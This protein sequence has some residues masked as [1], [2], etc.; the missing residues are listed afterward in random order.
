MTLLPTTDTQTVLDDMLTWMEEFTALTHRIEAYFA[1][2]EVRHRVAGNLKILL[3]LVERKNSLASIRA[4][5]KCSSKL[6]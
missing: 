3:S 1:R 5:S 2:F 6:I 4:E